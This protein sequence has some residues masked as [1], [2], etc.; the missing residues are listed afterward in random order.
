MDTPMIAWFLSVVIRGDEISRSISL[1][2]GA[3]INTIRE[4]EKE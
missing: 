4:K 1:E 2:E 3:P